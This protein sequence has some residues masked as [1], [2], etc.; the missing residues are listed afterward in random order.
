[1]F[2]GCALDSFFKIPD[3]DEESSSRDD[4]DADVPEDGKEKN[5]PD[6]AVANEEEAV[7]EISALVNY[8]QPVHFTSFEV[9]E[10]KLIIH[11]L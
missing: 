10:S 3:E 5:N 6:K 4:D 2:F 1:M 8:V 9:A 7:A 11:A